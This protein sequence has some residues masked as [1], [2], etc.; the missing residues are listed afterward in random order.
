MR[1]TIIACLIVALVA[2]ATSATAAKLITGQDIKNGSVTGADI[3]DKS[4]SNEDIENGKLYKKKLSKAVRDQLNEQGTPGPKGANGATGPQG[5]KGANGATG[6]K[7]DKG[8]K[9]DPGPTQ[10]SG[11]WGVLNR[12]TIGSPSAFLRSGPATPAVGP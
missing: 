1:R 9:G 8:D 11:N 10:S 12:N 5:P 3:K 7:G 6:P 4:I 2:G